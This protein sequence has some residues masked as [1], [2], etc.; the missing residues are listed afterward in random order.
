MKTKNLL[1]IIAFVAIF[2]LG[3]CS[4]DNNSSDTSLTSADAVAAN[5]MD[6]ASNDISDVVED[7][8]F[9]QNPSSAGKMRLHL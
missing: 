3:S 1:G 2:T 6:K 9:Q 4:K 7:V 5:K 8:Y